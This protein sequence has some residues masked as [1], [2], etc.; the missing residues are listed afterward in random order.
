MLVEKYLNNLGTF[1][2]NKTTTPDR[3]VI[4]GAIPN[5]ITLSNYG[6]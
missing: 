4:L 2:E 5:Q 6:I 1:K 3:G